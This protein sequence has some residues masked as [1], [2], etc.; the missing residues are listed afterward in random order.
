MSFE[1]GLIKLKNGC[2]AFRASWNNENV[3]YYNEVTNEIEEYADSIM[4]IW[5]PTHDDIVASD[6]EE[7]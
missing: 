3:L 1:E 5:N 2:G 6:W 7:A 4:R